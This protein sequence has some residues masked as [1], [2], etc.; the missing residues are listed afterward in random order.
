MISTAYLLTRDG[1]VGC[2]V[3]WAGKVVGSMSEITMGEFSSTHPL[4]SPSPLYSRLLVL[5]PTWANHHPLKVSHFLMIL[6][7]RK[8]LWIEPFLTQVS[9]SFVCTCVK[10]QQYKQKFVLWFFLVTAYPSHGAPDCFGPYNNLRIFWISWFTR[11][12]ALSRGFSSSPCAA[13]FHPCPVPPHCT[14]KWSA[15]TSLA[16]IPWYNCFTPSNR[17]LVQL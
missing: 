15:R 16:G 2:P 9:K 5:A 8:N 17:L 13:D 14:G 3:V 7:K 6:P 10:R 12:F 11:I 1:D 4:L